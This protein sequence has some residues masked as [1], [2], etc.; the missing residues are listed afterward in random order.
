MDAFGFQL[1]HS[2]SIFECPSRPQLSLANSS[3]ILSLL[4]S[5]RPISE[6][7]A[8]AVSCGWQDQAGREDIW[9][10]LDLDSWFPQSSRSSDA[11]EPM[12][13]DQQG[14]MFT[15]RLSWPASTPVDFKVSLH[16]PPALHETPPIPS[17]AKSEAVDLDHLK[18][19]QRS[20]SSMK[21]EWASSRLR[22]LHIQAS[23]SRFRKTPI[24]NG[25]VLPFQNLVFP[26]WFLPAPKLLQESTSGDTEEALR[27]HIILEPLVFGVLPESMLPGVA[28]LVSL[29]LLAQIFAVPRINAV[30]ERLADRVRKGKEKAE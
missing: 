7:E 17:K 28:L 15:V 25:G 20:S 24:N 8:A 12:H 13:N 2:S 26:S 9:V 29:L 1:A 18:D 10:V 30:F 21:R 27:F 5:T 3:T 16:N 6:Q 11:I 4:P 23:R 22:I 14:R 19:Q